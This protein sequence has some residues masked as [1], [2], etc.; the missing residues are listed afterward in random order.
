[1][2]KHANV[3]PV[4]KESILN[5]LNQ[6]RPISLTDIIMRL[7]ERSVFKTEIAHVTRHAIDSDQFAYKEGHNSIMA[8]IKCQHTWLRWLEGD[9]KYVRVLSFD[10]RKAFD[11]VPHDI[12]CEKLKKLPINPYV[13]NWL[14]RFLEDR[15]QRVVVDGIETEYLNI[16]QGVPQG[17]VLGPV[18][19]S[20]MVNDIKTVNPI[21]QL[22]KFA[23]D[24]TLEVPGNENGD[25]SQAE[26]NSIQTW[27]ENNRM[28]LN[29]E[30]TYEMIVRRN[31]P[32]LL[33][34]PFPFI[35]RRTWLKILGITLQD[36][37]SK[38]NLHFDE[39]LKKASARI[40]EGQT[41]GGELILGG[42]DPEHYTG[43]FTYVP[44][45]KKGYWQFKMDSLN[46]VDGDGHFCAGGCQ[47]VAD[48]GM[49]RIAGPTQEIK[50]LNAKI[51]ATPAISG[52][53]IID[54]SKIDSLPSVSI[55]VGGKNFTLTGAQYVI[56][57][58]LGQTEC[59]SGFMGLDVPPPWGPYW[60]LGDVF[61][62][63]YY[64]EFD[65][66]NDRVGFAKAT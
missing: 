25:T 26:V 47:A 56:K 34:D 11:S 33:P 57:T 8:L 5:S 28:S 45:T 18:L 16:N 23:D 59:L 62:G 65:M 29:M 40:K 19:F 35:K 60:I 46:I 42:S 13:T 4:P 48:T 38:W 44:V 24:M 58:I 36:L 2:W 43:D 32:T 10:F 51:G 14:I 12:L 27:S 64:T 21:N 50:E 63:P 6:L 1:M 49:S 17:T 61:I 20:I 7:F 66:A 3:L 22:V 30:K 54:C 52:A 53:Y 55:N 15:K 39:M 9:A 41:P 31:I 37:P